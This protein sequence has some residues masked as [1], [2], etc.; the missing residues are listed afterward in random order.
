[1]IIQGTETLSSFIHIVSE[2]LLTPVMIL[3]VV[4]LIV[5]ILCIG[6]L[7]NERISRKAISSE[8]LESLVRNVS[9]SQS[10]GE[11]EKHIEESNLFDFQKNVLVKIANN[12]D[13]G[14]EARKA[15]A[16]ELISAEETKL[17]KSTNKTDVLVRVGP[18]LGLLGTLIPLGPG[19]AALGSGDIVTL[20]EALTVAFDT[21][22]T[23]LVIGALAYLVSKFKKQW[24]ESDL[25]VLETI[26]EAE[27]ETLNRK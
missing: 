2:S 3:I 26:A 25:I 9:F 23:G 27:L 14:S 21:T 10:H 1:M 19:L 15:L 4:G 6:G 11:I 5:V 7:I 16:S 22:V 8:E 18:I 20:A 13:I 17:I 12:H 24:Y